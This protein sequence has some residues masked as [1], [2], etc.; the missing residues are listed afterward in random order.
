M[1]NAKR[2]N[3][4]SEFDLPSKEENILQLK[5]YK[6]LLDSGVISQD[7]F[8]SKKKEVLGL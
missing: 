6:E 2:N 8:D 3:I 7:E 4:S 1:W 5:K